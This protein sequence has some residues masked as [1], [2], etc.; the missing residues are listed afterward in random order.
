MPTPVRSPRPASLFALL[1]AAVLLI[2]GF[3][4]SAYAEPNEIPSTKV[5]QA[6]Q[7]LESA[8]GQYLEAEAALAKAKKEQS[9][10]NQTLLAAENRYTRVRTSVAKYA[11]EAYKS[12]RLGVVGVMLNANSPDEFLTRSAALEKMT[13]RDEARISELVQVKAE[14]S[15]AKAAVDASVKEQA[16]HL[17]EM[18]KLRKAADKALSAL[19]GGATLGWVDP[20]SPLAIPAKRN[21]DGTW[22]KEICS[23][24]DPTR[25]SSSA[26]ITPRTLHAYEQAREDGFKRYTSCWRPGD[27]YEHPKGRACD[28]SAAA[29]GFGG[30]AAGGDRTYGNKLAAYFV[31]NAR[32]LGV[33]Y[34]IWFCQVWTATGG[35]WHRY[36]PTGAKCGDSPSADHTDH[37]HLSVY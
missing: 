13:A 4:T 17:G 9:T 27:M 37:V 32:A 26:C 29:G 3:G 15:A 8:A 20:D 2:T 28:F 24:N 23:I 16:K 1:V 10:M 34:V 25:P 36:S 22:P 31:K 21:A 14:I 30:T 12:G 35:G 33:M 18:A 5:G 6:R 11:A 19:G 7:A